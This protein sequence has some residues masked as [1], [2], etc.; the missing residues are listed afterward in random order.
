MAAAAPPPDRPDIE[1]TLFVTEDE[2]DA[3]IRLAREEAV[4]PDVALREALARAVFLR[5]LISD[6][7]TIQYRRADGATGEISF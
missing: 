1:V 2:H 5:G 6:G 4:P 3:L 7:C